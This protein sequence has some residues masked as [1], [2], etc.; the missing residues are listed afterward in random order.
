MRTKEWGSSLYIIQSRITG[1]FKIGRSSKPERRLKELQTGSPY[2]LR[3]ILVLKDQGHEELELHR[4][5]K[6]Y[7]SQGRMKGEWFSEPGLASLPDHIYEQLDLEVVNTWWEGERG[8][9]EA[10]GPPKP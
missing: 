10:P 6:R 1:A 4:R 5:L 9:V 8:P 7:L 2:E 3:I